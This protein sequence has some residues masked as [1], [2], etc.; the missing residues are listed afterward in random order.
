MTDI[1]DI[2]RSI[3]LLVLDV[4]GVL[5]DGRLY[6]SA[7]GDETKMFHV[8]DGYGLKQL[9]K[10][11]IDVAVISGR[12][13]DTVTRR[14]KELGISHVHQGISDKLPVLEQLL[15]RLGVKITETAFVG[16]D[17]PDLEIMQQVALPVAVAD[18][19]EVAIATARIVT[20]NCG[21]RGAVREVC[22][23]ILAAQSENLYR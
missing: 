14:M 13:S 23:L 4:D 6:Y 20:R 8:R 1:T 19:H 10:S 3:R 9:M 5:T 18:A 12:N 16:D 7:A 22:D 11:G 2:A 17:A 21:G 15:N